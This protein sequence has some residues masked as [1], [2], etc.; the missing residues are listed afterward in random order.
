MTLLVLWDVDPT[1]VDFGD[2]G[3]IT[4]A[5]AF[6]RATGRPFTMSFQFGGLTELAMTHTVLAHHGVEADAGLV[7]SMFDHLARAHRDRMEHLTELGRPLPGVAAVLEA[8]AAKPGVRQTVLTGNMRAVGELKLSVSGLDRWLD[9]PIAAFG[10]DDLERA[11][12]LPRAWRNVA[13][14]YGESCAPERTVVIGDT[15]RDV[16]AALAHGAAI[17][18]VASGQ[19]TADALA[20]AGAGVVLA[21]LDDTEAVLAAIGEAAAQPLCW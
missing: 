9:L 8:L 17:V 6:S 15:V 4:Y 13:A 20:S 5:E 11:D 21:G 10:D 16:E 1:L 18:A 7:T 12:L 19:T 3:R 14:R 2:I